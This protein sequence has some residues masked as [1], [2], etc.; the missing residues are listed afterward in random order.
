MLSLAL[1][2]TV[3]FPTGPHTEVTAQGYIVYSEVVRECIRKL[4]AF[5]EEMATGGRPP[6]AVQ[7]DKVRR[8][9]SSYWNVVKSQPKSK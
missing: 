1:I 5:V 9:C 2:H 6:T 7:I 3:T 4:E 8:M